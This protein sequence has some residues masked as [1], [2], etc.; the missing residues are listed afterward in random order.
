MHFNIVSYNIHGLNQGY[1]LL[2]DLLK[3]YDILCIKEHWLAPDELYKL[4]NI[5]ENYSVFSS[6]AMD[7]RL[8]SNIFYDRPFGGVAIFVKNLYCKITSLIYKAD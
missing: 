4:N 8:S 3:D 5:N 7:N 1:G 6:S 2:P